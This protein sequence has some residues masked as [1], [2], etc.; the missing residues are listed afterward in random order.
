MTDSHVSAPEVEPYRALVLHEE[1]VVVDLIKLTLTHGAF[2]ARSAGSLAE[3]EGMLV[4]WT[5]Q[6]AVVDMDHA[7][8]IALLGLLGAS[9]TL[10][11]SVT[12]V[13]ALTM[14]GDLQTK[15]KAFDLGVDDILTVPF[16]P[17]ELLARCIVITRR[18][19][20]TEP[21][22]VPT[23]K[24]GEIEIDI[25]H[26]AVHAG[27]SVIPLSLIEQNLLYLLASR[28]GQAVTREEILDTIWGTDFVA[29]VN[30]VDRHVR[31]L[32]AKL[33]NGN[34]DRRFIGAVPGVGYRFSGW[35]LL[36]PRKPRRGS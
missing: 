12:P 23:I 34:R 36:A 18:R 1:P 13:L 7:D 9:S 29:E 5:P 15:L 33:Q 19:T 20:G 27:Q 3:A 2:V 31:S 21:P 28:S 35:Q 32:R 8:S 17:E 22:I 26:H 14:R 16:S 10:K 30:I 11:R 6:L 24:F 25:V 4:A